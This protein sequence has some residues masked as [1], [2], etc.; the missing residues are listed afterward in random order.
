VAI[1]VIVI[2]IGAGIYLSLPAPQQNQPVVVNVALS[3]TPTTLDILETGIAGMTVHSLL[4]D[5]LVEFSAN[6]TLV[7]GLA[8]SWGVSTDQLTWTFNL[9]QGVTFQDGSAFNASSVKYCFDRVRDPA[10]RNYTG[11]VYN[12]FWAV[13]ANISV[14][15]QYTVAFHLTKP[16][17]PFLYS[18]AFPNV[19]GVEST[20][21]LKNST[22]FLSYSD[23]PVGTGPFYVESWVSGEYIHMKANPNYWGVKPKID[24]IMFTVTKDPAARVAAL[25][26]GQV[27]ASEFLPLTALQ[28]FSGNTSINI[29]VK[30]LDYRTYIISSGTFPKLV[31]Q[32]MNYAVDKNA[33]VTGLFQNQAQIMTSPVGTTVAFAINDNTPYPYNP[34]LA[35]Q[36]LTEAGYPN[37]LNLTIR[38]TSGRY[39]NDLQVTEAIQANLAAIGITAHIQVD[40]ARNHV[41]ML[42]KN[43]LSRNDS[44]IANIG[45]GAGSGDPQTD[46]LGSFFD[47]GGFYNC[48]Y[49]N[50]T[51]QNVLNHA[52]QTA[53]P[54]QRTAFYDQAYEMIWEDAPMIWLFMGP[55][56]LGVNSHL[57][58][59]TLMPNECLNFREAYIV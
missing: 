57:K 55:C 38:T 15:D 14:V 11:K 12:R 48:Y 59:V 30:Q 54:A 52:M 34:T 7:P 13:V 35:R 43:V 28:T 51:V 49:S 45:W 18:L 10:N 25:Q 20:V 9:R 8:T 44:M 32:A 29:I 58:G 42:G 4:Y 46:I 33:I 24:E 47:V 41:N 31:R 6:T 40:E 26:S 50:A 5:R 1:A 53:D 37:G 39:M 16:F 17:S 2:I 19:G 21:A 36:L 56:I 23:H 22:T 3:D 27:D